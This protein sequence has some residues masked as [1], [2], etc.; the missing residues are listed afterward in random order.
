MSRKPDTAWVQ[1]TLKTMSLEDKVGQVLMSAFFDSSASGREKVVAAVKHYRLGGYFHFSAPALEL[2]DTVDAVQAALPVPLL[3][4]ADYEI[5][6]GWVV[7]GGI[8][9][10]RP[11][12]RGWAGTPEI[13]TELGREI[14]RQGRAVGTNVTFSPVVDLNT[15]PQNPDVNI[16]AYGEDAASV[17]RLAAAHVK[18]LQS[19]GMLAT[20]KHF[21]GNGATDQ[22]QHINTAI[23][24]LSRKQL[25][26]WI[27][28]YRKVFRSANP[29]CVMVAHLEVPALTSEI[30]PRT[31]RPVPSS[32]SREVI[33]GLLRD[34]LGYDGLAI[35]DAMNMGGVL[36]AYSREEAAVKAIQAGL[37]MLLLFSPDSIGVEYNAILQA[38]RSGAIPAARL[39]EAVRRVLEAKSRLGLHQTARHTAARKTIKALYSS[40]PVKE[41]CDRIAAQAVTAIR[42]RGQVLPIR[43]IRGKNVLVINTF[44]PDRDTLANQGQGNLAQ[45]D[46]TPDLLRQ[47]GAVVEE[48][49]MKLHM[50]GGAMWQVMDKAGKAD[51]VF[52][53]FFIIPTWAIGSLIPNK[54][55]LRLFMNGLLQ[56]P[57]PLVITAFGDPYVMYQF[58]AAGNV[59]LTFDE[60]PYAQEAAVRA[61]LGEAPVTGRSPVS[62]AGIYRRGDGLDC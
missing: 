25:A 46:L 10:P 24:P 61:W 48:I 8:K 35:S 11:M 6:P 34:E 7:P 33:Q 20:V 50:D 39:D 53:N 17:A 22:D 43:D 55:A 29:G 1:A 59:V 52:F 3:V 47:R 12:A 37:D 18:G 9:T 5:G 2:A 62:L 51:Y 28:T 57:R 60:T 42:N 14:A 40:D 15:H 58:P 21:P 49:E 23:I 54:S 41:L 32:T 38:A 4:A 45:V 19:R 56:N 44:N 26:P 36:V 31:G 13:E 16:R 30:N 27:Q